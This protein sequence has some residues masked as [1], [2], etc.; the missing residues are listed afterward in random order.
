M[1]IC[2]QQEIYEENDR[3]SSRI[4]EMKTKDSQFFRK[5]LKEKERVKNMEAREKSV[6]ESKDVK[7]IY[8]SSAVGI[9]AGG[10]FVEL[11][12]KEERFVGGKSGV[13]AHTQRVK[14]EDRATIV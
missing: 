12:G 7:M 4:A 10:R 11:T 8:S 6:K 2:R 14:K 1:T 9:L 3:L 13:R 5:I